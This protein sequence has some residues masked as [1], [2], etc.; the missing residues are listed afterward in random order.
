MNG[1]GLEAS[2]LEA[3]NS[4]QN[5][6]NSTELILKELFD[7][8]LYAQA[9]VFILACLQLLFCGTALVAIVRVRALRV[10]QNVYIVN[11]VFSDIVRAMLLISFFAYEL[12]TYEYGSHERRDACA[13]ILFLDLWQAFWS[14][15]ATVL[16]LQSR[17]ST[18]RDPLEAGITTGKATI[19]S[20]V[21]CAM[22]I[23]IAMPLFFTWTKYKVT[24]IIRDDGY[25]VDICYRD[26]SNLTNHL[27]FMLFYT[28]VSYWLP[29]SFVIYYL[30]RT[31]KLVTQSV[32]ERRKLSAVDSNSSTQQA[33]TTPF[34]K[35]KALWYVILIVVSNAVLPAPYIVVQMLHTFRGV[36]KNL[37]TIV[38]II[39]TLNFFVNAVLY[40]YWVRTFTRSLW[41]VLR[42]RKVRTMISVRN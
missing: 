26:V 31:L 29:F 16:I 40:C 38:G 22:G 9:S 32:R 14:M 35:S 13:F 6:S 1:S 17:H 24:Y 5:Q 39:F 8:D 18:I 36:E 7:A 20:V 4:T 37:L 2:G 11:L 34:Y 28:G 21:T 19:A 12:K 41:D 23:A 3:I 30:V 27:S 25:F 15:W 33:T 10:G 42:C